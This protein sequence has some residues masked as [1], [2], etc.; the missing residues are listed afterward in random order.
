MQVAAAKANMTGGVLLYDPAGT[1]LD[2]GNFSAFVMSAM[3]DD[4]VLHSAQ[5]T[6]TA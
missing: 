3:L 5:G 1:Q 4:Q 2:G 6:A